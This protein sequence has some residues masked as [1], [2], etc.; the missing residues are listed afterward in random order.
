VLAVTT[1]SRSR[2]SAVDDVSADAEESVGACRGGEYVLNCEM[3]RVGNEGRWYGGRRKRRKRRKRC[4]KE[5]GK[6]V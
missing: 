5:K 1:M 2:L 4:E 6:G 3:G